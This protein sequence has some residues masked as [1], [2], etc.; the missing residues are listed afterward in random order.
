[1]LLLIFVVAAQAA[2]AVTLA[3]GLPV[4]GIR[5]ETNPLARMVYADGGLGAILLAKAAIALSMVVLIA[6]Y[7]GGQRR[8]YALAGIAGGAGLLGAAGN[9]AAMVWH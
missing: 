8:R 2:D 1:V 5:D 9:V 4:V 7:R 6:L 3:F